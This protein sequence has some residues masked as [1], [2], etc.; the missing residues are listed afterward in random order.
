MLGIFSRKEN[1]PN[2]RVIELET[3]NENLK[4][5]LIIELKE[6]IKTLEAQVELL[7]KIPSNFVTLPEKWDGYSIPEGWKSKPRLRTM[8]EVSVALENI[9]RRKIG[10]SKDSK[11]AEEIISSNR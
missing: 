4:D 6:R 10:E 11:N 1:K 7:S 5:Q 2:Y 9:S 3:Q 8:N